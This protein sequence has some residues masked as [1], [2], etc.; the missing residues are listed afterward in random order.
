MNAIPQQYGRLVSA[1]LP[2]AAVTLRRFLA[3]AAGQPRYYWESSRDAIAFA[4]SGNAIELTGWGERRFQII[5]EK[6][7]E[8][9]AGSV[10]LNSQ[11]PMAAPRLFGGFSFRED[12][13]PDR[14]WWDFT[15]AHFVLPHYQLLQMGGKTWL[16]INAN[17]PLDE[18]PDGIE[19][20]LYEALEAKIA[21]LRSGE[22]EPVSQSVHP[23]EIDYPMPF[24]VWRDHINEATERMRQGVLKKVVL[25]RV[26]EVRF[27]QPV[28]VLGALDYLADAYP[29][30]YRFL[31]EPRPFHAFYG[32][33]PELLV[34]VEEDRVETMAL[35][36][37]IRRGETAEADAVYAQALLDSAKDRYE[38][39]LV[40]DEIRRRLEPL[41]MGLT[42]GETGV[43]RLSN[44]QHIHTPISARLR[45]QSGVLPLVD[46]LHPTPALGGEPREVAMALIS[47]M[48]PVPRGWYAA[49]IGWIDQ[50]LNGQFGVGIR[51]AVAQGRRVWM[52]AGAGIVA[53]SEPEKEWDETALK[54]R[55]MLD[56]LGIHERVN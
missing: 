50:H 36:G 33:T 30:T 28:N 4:G 22:D 6:A 8:L 51:S 25:S 18:A 52:Y 10:Y 5:H 44:I 1:S 27:D 3:Q 49:P 21:E 26:A 2:C 56:A 37:S 55:P 31:F 46:A 48:E 53:A 40:V 29:E 38:H 20:E 14:T 11:E 39:Q 47:E 43:M 23:L 12:F 7:Q 19:G 24:S 45:E 35:A 17:V 32:A 42:V 16:T 54:F 34:G 41:T 13:I 15:P 9:F